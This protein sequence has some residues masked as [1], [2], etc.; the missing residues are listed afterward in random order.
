LT[1][2]TISSLALLKIVQHGTR[3]LPELCAGCLLGLDDG[4]GGLEV[5]DG[6]AYPA[7]S[8]GASA[9][10][11][12]G[13]GQGESDAAEFREDMMKLLRDCNVDDFCVGWYRTV[14]MGDW[15]N[16]D[17]IEQQFEHQEDCDQ[18]TGKAKS[19]FLVYDPY[20]S[21]RGVLALK[22]FRL[23]DAFMEVMRARSSQDPRFAHAGDSALSR[24]KMSDIFYEIPIDFADGSTMSTLAL[25]DLTVGRS[26]HQKAIETSDIGLERLVLSTDPYLEKNVAFAIEELDALHEEQQKSTQYQKALQKQKQ[27]QDA[28]LEQ[29]RK[30]N[31]L[32]Q[33]RGEEL[34]PM[35]DPSNPIF[36]VL[37]DSSKLGSLLVR[38]QVDV[39][40]EQ[41]ND[42]S[43]QSFEKLFL[44]SAVQQQ[45]QQQSQASSSSAV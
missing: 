30:E 33:E 43:A 23:T 4:A 6:F 22:A 41:I 44:L 26:S 3:A 17:L 31:S 10:D 24:F 15:C 38:K 29:R 32:R 12:D 25:T 11:E 2:V 40:C 18:G 8:S 42:W 27:N 7:A 37:R 34:L 28:W 20:Q 19:C 39:Y 35:V 21:E 36:K 45:Q 13:S 16:I 1:K 9:D 14:N 5:T